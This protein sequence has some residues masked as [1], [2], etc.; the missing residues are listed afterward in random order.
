MPKVVDM[1]WKTLT[2]PPEREKKRMTRVRNI[3]FPRELSLIGP[4][5]LCFVFVFSS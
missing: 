1:D 4:L 5:S 2:T 3:L